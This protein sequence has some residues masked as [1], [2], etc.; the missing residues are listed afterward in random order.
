MAVKELVAELGGFALLGPAVG[1]AGAAIEVT[2]RNG[3]SSGE[4][5]Q[6][7]SKLA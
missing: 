2:P 6:I 3:R 5:R 1:G 4:V 7:V